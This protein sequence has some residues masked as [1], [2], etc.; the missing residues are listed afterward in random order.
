MLI[1]DLIMAFFIRG[2]GLCFKILNKSKA[3]EEPT[4]E[5]WITSAWTEL[6][7]IIILG[8]LFCFS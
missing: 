4:D 5:Y 2:H 7:F 6:C 1:H 8:A 3:D